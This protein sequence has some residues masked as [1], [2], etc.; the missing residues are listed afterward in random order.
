MNVPAHLNLSISQ[1]DYKEITKGNA[2]V[3]PHGSVGISPA[4][5]GKDGRAPRKK[6]GE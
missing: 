5:G 6:Q 3:H 2:S 1:F 4:E